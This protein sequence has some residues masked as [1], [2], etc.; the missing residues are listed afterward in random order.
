MKPDVVI[1]GQRKLFCLTRAIVRRSTIVVLDEVGANVD[2]KTDDL[3][4]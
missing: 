2:V 3:M 1:F 4:Q